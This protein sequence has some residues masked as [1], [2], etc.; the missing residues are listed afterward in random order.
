MDGEDISNVF[1]NKEYV[2]CDC[3]PEQDVE[4]LYKQVCIRDKE[5]ST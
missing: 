2:N 5:S 3:F 1:L 4:I